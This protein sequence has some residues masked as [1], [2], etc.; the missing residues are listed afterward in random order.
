MSDKPT[1]D[2][3]IQGPTFKL[4]IADLRPTQI[5]VGMIEVADKREE[6]VKDSKDVRHVY[7]EHHPVPVVRGPQG[8]FYL[9]DH[10]HLARALWDDGFHHVYCGIVGDLSVCSTAQFWSRMNE[11]HWVYPYDAQGRV[12]PYTAIP[13]TVEDLV[14][15]PYRSLAGYVRKA[16]G[17]Q[18][19]TTPF[20]EFLWANFFRTRV[21]IDPGN[22]AF[23]SAV[24]HAV[25]LAHGT[26]AA[27]LPGY[28]A[29]HKN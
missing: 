9:I 23:K 1:S 10:H 29:S 6:F 17:Y 28:I 21:K 14:D 26:D 20:A 3:L 13:Q 8:H 27:K 5:T 11:H 24:Q 25:S 12:Q 16:G 7:V 19:T 15:D 18:K 2:G 4:S 22:A